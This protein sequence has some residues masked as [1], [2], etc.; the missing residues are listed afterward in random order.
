MGCCSTDMRGDRPA[1]ARPAV[2]EAVLRLAD[3]RASGRVRFRGGRSHTAIRRP[4]I[5][6]DGEGIVR[7]D[8][9]KP[10]EV[11]TTPVTSGRFAAFAAGTGYA[12]ATE[13]IGRGMVFR[14]LLDDPDSVLPG[15]GGTPWWGAGE[16]ACSHTPEGPESSVEDHADHP[17]TH[18]AWD[19]AVA[20][21]RWAGRRLPTEAEWEH[22]ARGGLDD[23][24]FPWGNSE[25]DDTDL[26]PC[27]IV[28]GRFP[29]SNRCAGGW[30]GTSTVAAFAP[31]WR[32][33]TS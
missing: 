4:A 7:E 12:T 6:Q 5:P 11:E 28:Q 13:R 21:A 27:S 3:A 26:L 31:S 33:G 10:F 2:Q 32:S 30:R 9:L 8:R 18:I 25:P 15:G 29:A 20:V 19:D 1:G 22:A 17:V 16:G 24:R 14:G 23:P